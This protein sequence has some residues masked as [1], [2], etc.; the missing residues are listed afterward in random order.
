GVIPVPWAADVQYKLYLNGSE[1]ITDP[2]N[3]LTV[4]DGNGNTNSLLKAETCEKWTC[5]APPVLGYDWRDAVLYFVFV[6]RFVNGNPSNDG[7]PTSAEPAA[8]YKGG[9]Y[10]GLKSKID[11]G[12]FTDLGVNAL[13]I[14]VPMDNPNNR[15]IGT[16]GK[17]YSGYHGY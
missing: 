2:Q 13:W 5:A 15:E 12:Y 1:W 9:D 7:T 3:P 14:T 6:D 17:Y 8:E 16:D 4:N 10:A 11:A